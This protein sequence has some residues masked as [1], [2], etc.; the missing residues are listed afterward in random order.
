MKRGIKVVLS[1]ILAFSVFGNSVY[2]TEEE[3]NNTATPQP[4]EQTN[5]E[6]TSPSS[7]IEEEQK[8]EP[9]KAYV[10]K[11]GDVSYETISAA[12]EAAT[13]GAEIVLIMDAKEDVVVKSGK[14]VVLNLNGKTLTNDKDHTII[15]EG[16]LKITGNGIIDNV[17]HE[18]SV[19][20]NKVGG[21]ATLEGGSFTRSAELGVGNVSNGN[22]YYNILNQGNMT[23]KSGVKVEQNGSYSSLIA[24][25]WYSPKDNT[26]Q[27]FANLTID[28]GTFNGGKYI[29]N[30]DYGVMIINGGTVTNTVEAA[31]LN[32]NELTINGGTFTGVP[33][34]IANGGAATDSSDFAFEQGKLT[35]TNGN[36]VSALDGKIIKS[37]ATHA[38][39]DVKG[40]TYN[41]K[42]DEDVLAVKYA[43]YAKDNVYQ[44]LAKST[45]ITLSEKPTELEQYDTKTIT[46]TVE[47]EL[48]TITWQSS[49]TA[50]ATVVDGVITALKP[51]VVTITVKA[52]DIKEE[53]DLTVKVNQQVGIET[54]VSTTTPEVKI[55][56]EIE[57]VVS[58]DQ[59]KEIK[60]D[61]NDTAASVAQNNEVITDELK[62]N[63]L[64]QIKTLT[65]ES[66]L[67][68]DDVKI[69]IQTYTDIEVKSITNDA[70]KKVL[71]LDI[72]PKYNLVGT[73]TEV[74]TSDINERNSVSLSKNNE[75][76]VTETVKVE[77]PV[78]NLLKDANLSAE[79][80]KK[81]V[82]V[83]HTAHE[84]K[85]YYHNVE[86]ITGADTEMKISFTNANGFSQFNIVVDARIAKVSFSNGTKEEYRFGNINVK[87]PIP[88]LSTQDIFDGWKYK[89][90]VY[91]SLTKHLYEAIATAGTEVTLELVSHKKIESKPVDTTDND[92]NASKYVVPNTGVK[93]K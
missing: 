11:M 55:P 65:G 22:S 40:G 39:Y 91:T 1:F 35:I 52:A 43:A 23:I 70:G 33:C 81:I 4:T 42:P 12:L 71:T 18:R 15:N 29:K 73:K 83:E 3:D 20:Y 6:I 47:N 90:I 21:N 54:E 5:E 9:Q 84:G 93:S 24:N 13:S 87:L 27:T 2:A 58:K 10:A 77:V 85:V 69:I 44:V 30:D 34:A 59:M 67:T 38:I 75:L 26:T 88:A 32:W 80:L 17:T 79:E 36:F 25:G 74:K 48:D 14:N 68:M 57:S 64:E 89:G 51:G 45:S 41:V 72:T 92:G 53:W 16:T 49:D 50:V 82:F 86:N 31:I 7:P 62:T 78:G 76:K 28:G 60:V 56:S 46:A 37:H 8:E 61:L 63:S 19:L 66:N